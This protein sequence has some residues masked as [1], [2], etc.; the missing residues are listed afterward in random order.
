MGRQIK[1]VCIYPPIPDRRFDWCAFYDGD[2]ESG[3]IGYGATEAEAIE[4]FVTNYV[5]EE[6]EA[7]QR[8]RDADALHNGGLSPLG[9]ALVEDTWPDA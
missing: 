1:T 8:E 7:R 6:E 9:N 4:D 3:R 2:E 5:D